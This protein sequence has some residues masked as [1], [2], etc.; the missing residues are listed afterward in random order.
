MTVHLHEPSLF[1]AL[2]RNLLGSLN[3]RDVN[4]LTNLISY[5]IGQKPFL[6]KIIWRTFLASGIVHD[7]PIWTYLKHIQDL[8][9]T[10]L[11]S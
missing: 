3:S 2:T 7:Y 1:F 11:R 6:N 5:K 10:Y 4:D 8:F 9:K